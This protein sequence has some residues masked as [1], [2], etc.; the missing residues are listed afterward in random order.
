MLKKLH[1]SGNRVLVFSQMTAL[2][3]I[4]QVCGGIRT[5]IRG[6]FEFLSS[7][8]LLARRANFAISQC[9]SNVVFLLLLYLPFNNVRTR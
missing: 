5:R 6:D 9:S 4:L 8:K 3:D 2:L 1:A 7:L